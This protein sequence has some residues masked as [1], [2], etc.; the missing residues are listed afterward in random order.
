VAL[1]ISKTIAIFLFFVYSA[2]IFQPAYKYLAFKINQKYIV[3]ALCVEREK[4]VNTCQGGCYLSK[5]MDE[6]KKEPMQSTVPAKIK[7]PELQLEFL[8][9]NYSDSK[10]FLNSH[11]MNDNI[12]CKTINEYYEPLVPPPKC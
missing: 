8:V 2:V 10:L 12:C 1:V 3:E 9:H 11:T 7:I 5:E 4:E 6:T